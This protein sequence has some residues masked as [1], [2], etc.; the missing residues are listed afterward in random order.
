MAVDYAVKYAP[1]IDERFRLASLTNGAVNNDYDFIGVRTVKVYSIP[2]ATLNDY[3]M[4]G[5]SRYGTPEELSAT[6]QELTLTQDKA[7]TF[8]VDSRNNMDTNG[9]LAA[10]TA[11]TRQ[12]EEVIV[13]M[14]DMYR[15]AK[16][17]AGASAGATTGI[18]LTSSNAFAA[19]LGAEAWMTDHKVPVNGRVAFVTPR[20]YTTIRQDPL[21]MLPSEISMGIAIN[22]MVG[23]VDGVPL[24]LVP[25]S[26]MPAA[27]IDV[28]M[29]HPVVMVGAQKLAEYRTTQDPP[30]IS[31]MLVE[32]RVY[33]D[34]FV[35]KNKA[36][37]IYVINGG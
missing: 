1:Q 22:G 19:M 10:A 11:L 36:D 20:F 18:T 16:L 6:T 30:G 12:I 26:Y 24:V 31:G 23:R 13:P 33:Y 17:A 2:T 15:L 7:F 32:G 25:T 28:I 34:A 27:G 8:T 14:I 29:T 9:A 35:L 5:M 37:G 21:F 4:S 3:T